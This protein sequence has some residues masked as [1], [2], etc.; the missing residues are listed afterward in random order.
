MTDTI[1]GYPVIGI[2][3]TKQFGPLPLVDMPM[4]SDEEWQ[5]D[6]DEQVVE[7]YTRINS[8]PPESLE[9]AYAWQREWIAGMEELR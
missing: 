1:L 7:N 3:N 2:V 5:R 9:A 4:M 8:R 6:A